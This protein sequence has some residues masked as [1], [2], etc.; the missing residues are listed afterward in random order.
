LNLLIITV[1]SDSF[2][3]GTKVLFK[4]I[5]K[6]NNWFEG[7]FCVIDAG[8]SADSKKQLTEVVDCGFITPSVHLDERIKNFTSL[9]PGYERSKNRFYSLESFNLPEYDKVL[10]LDSDI[11]CVG[12]IEELFS[13]EEAISAVPDPRYFLGYI[14]HKLS[15]KP[16]FPNKFSKQ[17]PEQFI[18]RL[19]NTGMI[20][21]GKEL[22]SSIVF[23]KLVSEIKGDNYKDIKTGHTDTV[24]LNNEYLSDINWLPLKW[25][26][27][28]DV[29]IDDLE[30]IKFIHY[31]HK[32]KPW[33]IKKLNNATKQ[34]KLWVEMHNEL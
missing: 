32:N 4:S 7:A 25:N 10:Y 16:V 22:L 33:E 12:N 24:I 27:Y 5:V 3:E 29:D 8:L 1:S 20:L 21:I 18:D 23:D 17:L 34:E 19:F 2:I 30:D 9:Y 26:A 11:L 6:N 14:R 28:T 13:I 15:L 31:L